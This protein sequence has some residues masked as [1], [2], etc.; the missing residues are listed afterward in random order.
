MLFLKKIVLIPSYEP[1]QELVKLINRI[2][3]KVFDVIVV[4]DGS[5]EKYQSIFDEISKKVVV[6]GYSVNQGK[7][8]ALKT[9][10]QYIRDNYKNDF[11]VVTMDSDGQHKIEDAIRLCKYVELHPDTLVLGKRLRGNNTP[12][13]S[14]IG[15]EI[16]KF[17]YG[18]ATGVFVYDTQT[19]LRAFSHQLMDF[20]LRVDGERFEYEMRVLLMAAYE[21]IPMHEIQIETIY[22]NNNRGSHFDTFKDSI[23]I[24]KEI[25]KFSLSS[26]LSFLIDYLLFT[27]FFFAFG[28]IT[29]SNVLARVISSS[30]NYVINRKHVFHSDKNFYQ[31]AI[32]YFLLA[33]LILILNTVIL[34]IFVYKLFVNQFVAK[35]I[36]EILL[37]I[38]S[39]FVQKRI[40]F[41]K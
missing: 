16:T 6:L 18:I 22:K 38:F 3:K 19:G 35:I 33:I 30:F 37:F 26:I 21:K 40:V 14:K 20:H 11:V 2:D 36:T 5:G 25:I 32:L 10:F 29:L 13:R 1:D 12:I 24:Y 34:N 39:W 17:V 28:A 15:N 7:G 23:R 4:N 27:I 41:K 8:H 31:S 9:G